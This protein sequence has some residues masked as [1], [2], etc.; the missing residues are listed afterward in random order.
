M[1]QNVHE[2]AQIFG[3]IYECTTRK[4]SEDF[5]AGIYAC[6]AGCLLVIEKKRAPHY[7]LLSAWLCYMNLR[8]RI[9]TLNEEPA[10]C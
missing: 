5:F 1:A 7:Y 8:M 9:E 4:I 6:F 2:L 3:Q 10:I